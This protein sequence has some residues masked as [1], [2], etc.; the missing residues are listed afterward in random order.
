MENLKGDYH[1]C[2]VF[3]EGN[4]SIPFRRNMYKGLKV[5]RN[6]MPSR[7]CKQNNGRGGK[8]TGKVDMGQTE[9]RALDFSLMAIRNCWRVLTWRWVLWWFLSEKNILAVSWKI[10]WRKSREAVGIPRKWPGQYCMQEVMTD[11][12]Q[13]WKQ[14]WSLG[15]LKDYWRG[16]IHF[17]NRTSYLTGGR[18]KEKGRCQK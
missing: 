5:Q 17:I 9:L 16:K 15:S 18:K 8:K 6:L 2:S 1:L 10:N 11:W 4:E 14:K 7:I 13:A 12:T 3:K